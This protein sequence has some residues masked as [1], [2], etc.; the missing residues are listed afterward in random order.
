MSKKQKYFDVIGLND[1]LF[2]SKYIIF[3]PN[4]NY[5]VPKATPRPYYCEIDF[6][7][8]PEL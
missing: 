2:S 7:I 8:V 4:I 1:K 6:N 5:L 3:R